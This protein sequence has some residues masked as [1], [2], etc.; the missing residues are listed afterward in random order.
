MKTIELKNPEEIV[1]YIETNHLVYKPFEILNKGLKIAYS[2]DD[3][4]L[5]LPSEGFESGQA[6]LE[7]SIDNF[8]WKLIKCDGESKKFIVRPTCYYEQEDIIDSARD[9][10]TGIVDKKQFQ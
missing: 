3:Y 7:D 9:P 10:N 5:L 4:L 1:N 2:F 8:Y 6:L